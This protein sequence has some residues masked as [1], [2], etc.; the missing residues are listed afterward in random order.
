MADI[1]GSNDAQPASEALQRGKEIRQDEAKN[2]KMIDNQDVKEILLDNGEEG[3]AQG[4]ADEE[5][6]DMESHI[7]DEAA[8]DREHKLRHDDSVVHD[9]HPLLHAISCNS[10]LKS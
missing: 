6:E 3:K 4:N 7:F 8:S 5:Y 10:P 1:G 2:N 9:N